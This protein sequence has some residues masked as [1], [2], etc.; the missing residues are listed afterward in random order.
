MMKNNLVNTWITAW[1][2]AKYCVS[3]LLATLLLAS[4]SII[5]PLD[6]F[7]LD[8]SYRIRKDIAVLYQLLK[9][10]PAEERQYHLFQRDY[11]YIVVSLNVLLDRQKQRKNNEETTKIV[12]EI[13]SFV[14]KYRDA[15]KADNTYKD[16]R[17]ELHSKR[18]NSLMTALITAE[19]AKKK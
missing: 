8:E 11:T 13:L 17:I 12:E 9:D 5:S 10:T 19:E 2:K 1:M 14:T 7:T 15:H 3:M 18:L 4:C 6:E 16:A